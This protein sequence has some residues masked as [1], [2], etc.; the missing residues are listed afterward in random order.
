MANQIILASGSR[1]RRQLMEAAGIAFSAVPAEIDEA[2][3][4]DALR[5]DNQDIDPA[6]IAELLAE[7]KAIE[8]G[9]RHPDALVIGADQVLALAGRLYEKPAD[10]ERA[11]DN[12]LEL[13]GKT[14]QLHSA[15]TLAQRGEVVWRH[16][17]TAH[18]TMR[19]FTPAFLG[20]YLA[21]AGEKV[22]Q[23]V[24]AYQLEGL[25]I[26]LFEKVEGD[27]FTILGLPMLPLLAELRRRGVIAS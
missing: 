8:V 24:G 15:V 6:D 2:A 7:A 13:R 5:A 19:A 16:L 17:D 10:L 3:I 25:G 20:S 23:S 4:R 9:N 1:S 14:H 12:L 18:M 11:R 27:Y 26:Q 21:C 22:C